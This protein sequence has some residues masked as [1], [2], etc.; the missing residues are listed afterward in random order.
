M[1]PRA[2]A[3]AAAGGGWEDADGC[4][5][6]DAGAAEE[7]HAND[8]TVAAAATAAAPPPGADQPADAATSAT[9]ACEVSP[10]AAAAAAEFGRSSG[11]RGHCCRRGGRG[12]GAR[13][14]GGGR[15]PQPAG[16]QACKRPRLLVES[17]VSSSGEETYAANAD[18]YEAAAVA[19]V[20]AGAPPAAPP[21]EAGQDATAATQAAPQ[22][23][24]TAAAP[25]PGA[26]QPTDAG[27]AAAAAAPPAAAAV[28]AAAEVR[29][30]GGGRSPQEAPGAAAHEAAAVKGIRT[31]K[32]GRR[33]IPL[34][35]MRL[36][37]VHSNYWLAILHKV[38]LVEFRSSRHPTSIMAGHSLLFAL[39]MRHRRRGNDRLIHARVS[40]VDVLDVGKACMVFARES[41]DCRLAELALRWAVTRVR[42]FALEKS[43]IR[44]AGEIA[45]LSRGCESIVHQFA[46][47]SGVPQF[48]H[49][50]DLGKLVSVTLPGGRIEH[51]T[52]CRPISLCHSDSHVHS[53]H[54]QN[55]GA[56]NAVEGLTAAATAPRADLSEVRVINDDVEVH[57]DRL[58]F[59]GVPAPPNCI[60]ARRSRPTGTWSGPGSGVSAQRNM[61]Q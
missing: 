15:S 13:A 17:D 11:R 7:P 19:A 54:W 29:A 1:S 45:N 47:S 51:R 41:A 5:W 37:V 40:R 22:A 10:G 25:S 36:A 42:C 31:G 32:Q 8:A 49:V 55:A 57:S 30:D 18:A 60:L 2:A 50:S 43:S 16:P 35:H 27:A 9:D 20:A 33:Y 6:E 14:D 44:I 3:A 48:C 24:A 38:K 53:A 34:P 21:A 52:L 61:K 26:D 39:A 56:E 59:D 12:S 4:G 28:A 23:G 58:P 46:L